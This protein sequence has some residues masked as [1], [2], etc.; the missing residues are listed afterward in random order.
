MSDTWTP[1]VVETMKAFCFP[2]T[3]EFWTRYW[4]DPLIYGLVN[5]LTSVCAEHPR[6]SMIE[7]ER[8]GYTDG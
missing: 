2:T 1:Q 5:V 6:S 7:S 8:W 4:T 3:A